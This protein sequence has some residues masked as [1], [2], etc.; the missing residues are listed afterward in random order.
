VRIGR[1][2]FG[3]VAARPLRQ[4]PAKHKKLTRSQDLHFREA[5]G[6]Q[7][8]AALWIQ[9]HSA[10]KKNTEKGDFSPCKR[11]RHDSRSIRS[12][13]LAWSMQIGLPVTAHGR[14]VRKR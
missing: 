11:P 6:E 14:Q 2:V 9:R 1:S 7:H 5:G 10:I 4:T 12:D 8:A 3:S 13:P